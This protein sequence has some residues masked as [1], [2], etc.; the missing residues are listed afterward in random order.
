MK[1][2]HPHT[3]LPDSLCACLI[4]QVGDPSDGCFAE[5]MLTADFYIYYPEYREFRNERTDRRMT[6]PVFWWARERDILAELS[7]EMALP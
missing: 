6:Q 4:A 5:P 3:E 2:W 7:A 1:L